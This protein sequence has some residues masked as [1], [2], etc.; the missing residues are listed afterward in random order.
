MQLKLFKALITYQS[1]P[2]VVWSGLSLYSSLLGVKKKRK[3]GKKEKNFSFINI[4]LGPR[5]IKFL[6]VNKICLKHNS[7]LLNRTVIKVV[8][9]A[10][11]KWFC[12]R[13]FWRH[14]AWQQVR[15][16]GMVRKNQPVGIPNITERTSQKPVVAIQHHVFVNALWAGMILVRDCI[17][18]KITQMLRREESYLCSETQ[19]SPIHSP[20][21][22]LWSSIFM[23]SKND[24]RI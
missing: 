9:R 3:G 7:V 11:R 10:E 13:I 23:W 14:C 2:W 17:S 4:I 21:S 24:G 18:M 16:L 12:G 22:Y 15:A 6:V 5:K 20:T 19:M 1:S 8:S